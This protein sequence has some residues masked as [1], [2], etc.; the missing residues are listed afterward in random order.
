M[1]ALAS[2]LTPGPA[3]RQVQ[4]T[5]EQEDNGG[6]TIDQQE[7]ELEVEE[8]LKL[9]SSYGYNTG[10]NNY[11]TGYSQPYYGYNY[12]QPSNQP[13]PQ[14]SGSPNLGG[15]LGALAAA[16]LGIGTLETIL[17]SAAVLGGLGR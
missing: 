11:N 1:G 7:L 5:S 12:Y 9:C 16:G 17:P 8:F 14:Q 10:Y 2:L 13:Y 3:S 4:P 6:T 15:L